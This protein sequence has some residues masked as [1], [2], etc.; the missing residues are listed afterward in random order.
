[1]KF[2]TTLLQNKKHLKKPQL[3]NRQS[4]FTLI[5]AMVAIA[6]FTIV[7]VIGISALLSVN[8]T[9]K[10]S[11]NLRAIID[12]LN[13]VMEDM[14]RNFK[15]G[16][17]Y[18]CYSTTF[19]PGLS[20]GS[21]NDFLAEEQDCDSGTVDHEGSLVVALE[22]MGGIPKNDDTG[23]ANAEDQVIYV[24][25]PGPSGLTTECL[26]E[27]STD[28]G[29]EFVPITTTPDIKIDC[30]RSGFNVY[31]TQSGSDFAAAPR[32]VMRISGVVTYKEVTTSFSL[33]TSAS[34]RNINVMAP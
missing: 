14:S 24:F 29:R 32:I 9:N 16:S 17:Y 4:G 1:M 23:T 30:A 20:I 5:E 26:L 2:L 10:K 6:I 19:D 12:N 13:Y 18:H 31:N 28:G 22:P 33:Q 15:L 21:V 3:K 7:M 11:Q 25:R 27:K 34:Q 8:N